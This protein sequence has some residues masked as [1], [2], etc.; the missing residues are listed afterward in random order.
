MT[1]IERCTTRFIKHLWLNYHID[2][3]DDWELFKAEQD[4]P[5]PSSS[6]MYVFKYNPK[7]G[8]LCGASTISS[9]YCS[10]H[11]NIKKVAKKEVDTEANEKTIIKPNLIINPILDGKIPIRLNKQI[12]KYVHTETKLVFF[13]KDHRVVYGKLVGHENIQALSEKDILACKAFCFKY[14][15]ELLYKSAQ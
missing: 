7:R 6:C 5:K 10:L 12:N 4:K 13:S 3:S 15:E 14:D 2:V 11:A 1:N 8:E 9:S